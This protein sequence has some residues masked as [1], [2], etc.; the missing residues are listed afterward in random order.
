MSMG[1]GEH[2][3]QVY[4]TKNSEEVSWY[5]AN[6]TIS[7]ELIEQ[8]GLSKADPIID[9]GGG[10]SLLVD[11]LLRLGY[12]NLTVLD[13][14]PRALELAK[15]RLGSRAESIHW[16]CEDMTEFH[17]EHGYSLWH[18]RAVFHF[19]VDQALRERYLHILR[20]V[21][22][23]GSHLVLATFGP[24]GPSR[25]SGLDV[26]RYSTEDVGALLGPTFQLRRKEIELHQTPAGGFQQFQYGWWT[27]MD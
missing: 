9:I 3:Q 13:I 27:V 11:H 21:L 12:S 16:I 14:A 17:A 15:L 18:D 26:L 19:L 2:W 4:E 25:C 24:E 23:P 7:L 22:V 5:Q 20:T 10:A 1:S 6:P 8:A